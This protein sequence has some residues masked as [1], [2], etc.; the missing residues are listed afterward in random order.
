MI[1][2]IIFIVLV[3]LIIVYF[4]TKREHFHNLGTLHNEPSTQTT[5]PD[6]H[7]YIVNLKKDTQ[8]KEIMQKQLDKYDFSYEFVEAVDGSKLDVEQLK[9]EDKIRLYGDQLKRG[10][11]GCYLSHLNIYKM[12]LSST[13]KYCIVL[14]DDAKLVDDFDKHIKLLLSEMNSIPNNDIDIIYLIE[15][16]HC[17]RWFHDD[18]NKTFETK[19]K[20]TNVKKISHIGYHTHGYLITKS[21]AEKL[22]KYGTVM[23]I[24][25]DVYIHNLNYNNVLNGYKT[26]I[27][28]V[29]ENTDVSNISNTG[30][31]L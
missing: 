17:S 16:K 28:F 15:D 30:N 7:I 10:E 23:T 3:L 25:I 18:C 14:E 5:Y 8:R 27:P 13:Y 19:I 2:T 29:I 11:Y 6:V 1:N 4:T 26:T 22:I 24:P 31:I 21:G 20:L 9:K 12:F